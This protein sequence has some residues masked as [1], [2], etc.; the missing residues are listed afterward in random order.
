MRA[1]DDA[2]KHTAS[3]PMHGETHCAARC[4]LG[5]MD[6]S[7]LQS[8]M[9]FGRGRQGAGGRGRCSRVAGL[10]LHRFWVARTRWCFTVAICGA[11]SSF[12]QGC[13]NGRAPAAT[14]SSGDSHQRV[15]FDARPASQISTLPSPTGRPLP[16]CIDTLGFAGQH[17]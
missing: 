13:E 15:R 14:G 10:Q 16:A 9:L 17:Q 2:P 6:L 7:F 4:L 11:R 3:E 12:V 1:G 8:R 5:G